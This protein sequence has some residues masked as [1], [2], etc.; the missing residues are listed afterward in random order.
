MV[1]QVPVARIF[2]LPNNISFPINFLDDTT[3][4]TSGKSGVAEC[5]SPEEVA[6][7][8]QVDRVAGKIF[9]WPGMN[10]VPIVIDQI[11]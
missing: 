8:Q 9:S 3:G 6:I 10:H 11:G 2:E 7:F 4:P 1:Q 5:A